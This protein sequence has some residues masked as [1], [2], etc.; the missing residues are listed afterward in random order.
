M[1]VLEELLIKIGVKVDSEEVKAYE[2]TISGASNAL[3][4][5]AKA[6]M[7]AAA[8]VVYYSK[9][10]AESED[11]MIKFARANGLAYD[12][13]Q[14]LAYAAEQ[15][16]GSASELMGTLA[17]LSN[18]IVS[19]YRDGNEALMRLGI[20]VKDTNGDFKDS[21]ALLL[22]IADQ[23]QGFSKQEQIN[24][25]SGIGISGNM[26]NLMMQ[27]RQSIRQYM[28][29]AEKYG[30]QSEENAKKAEEL[31]NKLSQAK[32]SFNESTK[33]LRSLVYDGLANLMKALNKVI[34]IG[35]KLLQIE[36][37]DWAMG[38]AIAI[39][40]LATA[41]GLFSVVKFLAQIGQAVTSIMGLTTSLAALDAVKRFGIF[42]LVGF[43]LI[44]GTA[45]AAYRG[46]KAVRAVDSIS[47]A[48][49]RANQ[50]TEVMN[51]QSTRFVPQNYQSSSSRIINQDI[52]IDVSGAADPISVGREVKRQFHRESTFGTSYFEASLY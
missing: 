35:G 8:A 36:I 40:T 26:I 46:I 48:V 15:E 38:A 39:G 43:G 11:A 13:V 30:L 24:I 1:T 14:R 44:A 7:A 3:R 23:L 28:V 9:K 21:I 31:N 20:S 6:G 51:A 34:E 37:A 47:N 33:E 10:T 5:L 12:S 25:L 16:G 32:R 19:A 4:N 18:T 41:M 50:Q 45:F 49:G 29:D 27:G 52:K 22:D 42:G 17:G 2:K